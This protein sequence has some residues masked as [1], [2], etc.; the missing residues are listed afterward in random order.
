VKE[1][2]KRASELEAS[3]PTAAGVMT[4]GGVEALAA[5]VGIA[6]DAVRLAEQSLR[7]PG[8]SEPQPRPN[9][10]IKGPT[11]LAFERV[12]VGELPDEEYPAMV[13]EIRNVLQTP[14][15]VSQFGRS[16]SWIATRRGASQ[17]DLE[18]A[19]SVR[20]GRTRITI[21][22]NLSGLIGA[23]YGGIG[24]GMGGGGMGPIMGILTGALHMAAPVVIAIVPL[25]LATTYVTARTVYHASTRKR[26]QE[27]ERLAD[28]L[29]VLAQ[30]LIPPPRPL[31]RGPV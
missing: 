13:E 17:R 25:W 8:A 11:A 9:P 15:Q 23:V 2:V 27:L 19:V 22:E 31:L 1:I 29:A 30:E 5:E 10:W 12:A 18:V 4:I 28:R 24:G 14:G 20:G 21:K 3:S 26:A 16:F 6:P 7:T